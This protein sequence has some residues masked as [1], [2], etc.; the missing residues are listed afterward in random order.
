MVSSLPLLLP[1][2]EVI[3]QFNVPCFRPLGCGNGSQPT[4]W[5]HDR[6]RQTT[7]FNPSSIN[8]PINT[9][10][11]TSSMD[12]V[13]NSSLNSQNF[14][15][16][17]YSAL[18]SSL[19]DQLLLTMPLTDLSIL[20]TGIPASQLLPSPPSSPLMYSPQS[21]QFPS[22]PSPIHQSP[23]ASTLPPTSI[24]IPIHSY[25]IQF[26]KSANFTTK[27]KPPNLLHL[28][29]PHLKPID[30][31]PNLAF[32]SKLLI[33]NFKSKYIQH[34]TKESVKCNYPNCHKVLSKS[35]T[36]CHVRTHLVVKRY[37]CPSCSKAFLRRGDCNR[38]VIRSHVLKNS[39]SKI[40]S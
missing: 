24:P 16:F 40:S 18:D 31:Y 10:P 36:H 3:E 29:P 14:E 9:Q 12:N 23:I 32:E 27:Y 17:C 7:A 4:S 28:I 20:D 38:H 26:Q 25:P 8:T 34:L 6:Q 13:S 35:S 15:S 21:F 19:L 5:S 39:S 37:V 30:L 11:F 1:K 2:P 22:L 33:K